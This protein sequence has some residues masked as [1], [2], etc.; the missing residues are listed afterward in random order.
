MKKL[1][2]IAMI[3]LLALSSCELNDAVQPTQLP[4]E[5]QEGK[6]IFGCKVNGSLWVPFSRYKT[7]ANFTSIPVLWGQYSGEQLKLSANNQGSLETFYLTV[8]QVKSTGK[9]QFMKNYPKNALT[10]SPFASFYQKCIKGDCSQYVICQDC[11]NEVNITHFDAVQ[12]I[13]SG[14]FSVTFKK[15]DN[16]DFVTITEGRFDVKGK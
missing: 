12:N 9:F 13:Y 7:N 3:S 14:T 6:Q 11:P 16:S 10:F 2:A 4:A 15:V 5:S 8:N 1:L